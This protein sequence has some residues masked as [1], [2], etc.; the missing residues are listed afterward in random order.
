VLIDGLVKGGWI[1]D[2]ST[3]VIDLKVSASVERGHKATRIT[4]ET[5]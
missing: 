4:L 2:D 3:D 5:A 1:F